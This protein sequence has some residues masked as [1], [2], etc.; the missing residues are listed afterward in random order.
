MDLLVHIFICHHFDPQAHHWQNR[1]LRNK[2]IL[3]CPPSTTL[4]WYYD[5]K[6]WI[7]A[8]SRRRTR[9]NMNAK[10]TLTHSLNFWQLSVWQVWCR[11]WI[12]LMLMQYFQNHM[13]KYQETRNYSWQRKA[14]LTWHVSST[15]SKRL[16]ESSGDTKKR[17]TVLKKRILF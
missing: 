4:L 16:K 3:Q 5:N 17:W 9:A 10:W 8:M 7:I 15:A 13:L 6:F 14:F 11:F 2:V 1:V 12:R